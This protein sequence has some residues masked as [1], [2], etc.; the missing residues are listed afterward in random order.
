MSK[1]Q[2]FLLSFS[3]LSILGQSAITHAQIAPGNSPCVN[4]KVNSNLIMLDEEAQK[5]GFKLSYF[6]TL[7]APNG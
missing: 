2:L 1:K 7:G 5:I 4:P 6:T 3:F